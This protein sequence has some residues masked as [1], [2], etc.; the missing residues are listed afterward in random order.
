MLLHILIHSDLPI[1]TT[2][3]SFFKDTYKLSDCF[4]FLPL[5]QNDTPDPKTSC[6]PYHPNKPTFHKSFHESTIKA[7]QDTNKV[8]NKVTN[9]DKTK[10]TNQDNNKDTSLKFQPKS[11]KSFQ[12]APRKS[13]LLQVLNKE[14]GHQQEQ[15]HDTIAMLIVD[16]D[17]NLAAGT[18]TNGANHKIPG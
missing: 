12:K 7:N 6:G 1:L 3:W 9:Q 11:D 8:S 18:T 2:C 10:V 5:T 13:S 16:K 14:Q 15:G 17:G 4:C